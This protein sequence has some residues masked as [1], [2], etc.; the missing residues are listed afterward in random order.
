M[1]HGQISLGFS[2]YFRKVGS[3]FSV[4]DIKPWWFCNGVENWTE[5]FVK[6][7]NF[8]PGSFCINVCILFRYSRIYCSGLEVLESIADDEK[9]CFSVTTVGFSAVVTPSKFVFQPS[10]F[11]L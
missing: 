1:L 2:C 3:E 9:R 7:K 8:S 5:V 4:D 6:Y 10:S 11:R